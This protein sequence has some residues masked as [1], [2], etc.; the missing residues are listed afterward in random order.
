MDTVLLAKRMT[1]ILGRP[2]TSAR[3]LDRGAYAAVYQLIEPISSSSAHGL[4]PV[5]VRV[6][7]RPA[8]NDVAI[9]QERQKILHFV[10]TLNYIQ[11]EIFI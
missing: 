10:G 3:M 1:E 7:S 4:G 9:D 11:G 8:Y 2:F 6:S 5:V